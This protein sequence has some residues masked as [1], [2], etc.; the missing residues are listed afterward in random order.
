MTLCGAGRCVA[1]R[2]TP[3][4]C[5]ASI[6]VGR[7]LV[8]GQDLRSAAESQMPASCHSDTGRPS[9]GRRW[10]GRWLPLIRSVT[11]KVSSALT[12]DYEWTPD[13]Y[14]KWLTEQLVSAPAAWRTRTV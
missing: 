6:R 1:G 11:S 14:G 7:T 9:G 8:G 13:D 2:V 10:S 12:S 4:P 5:P 3:V